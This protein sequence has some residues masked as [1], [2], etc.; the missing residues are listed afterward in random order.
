MWIGLSVLGFM[1]LI[2]RRCHYLISLYFNLHCGFSNTQIK[3]LKVP[4]TCWVSL[5]DTCCSVQSDNCRSTTVLHSTHSRISQ[6][7]LQASLNKS[8]SLPRENFTQSSDRGLLLLS[9]HCAA[10]YTFFAFEPPLSKIY[11][12]L[13]KVDLNTLTTIFLHQKMCPAT[14]S[15]IPLKYFMQFLIISCVLFWQI[16]T[17]TGLGL[18]FSTKR[19]HQNKLFTVLPKKERKKCEGERGPCSLHSSQTS[20]PP[21]TCYHWGCSKTCI[22]PSPFFW[23]AFFFPLSQWLIL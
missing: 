5:Q 11:S 9:L 10:T 1:N 19:G 8:R 18:N 2:K 20:P 12:I 7:A 3:L 22:T 14:A 17:A 4:L 15:S 21:S 16:M 23:S 13:Y 6:Q